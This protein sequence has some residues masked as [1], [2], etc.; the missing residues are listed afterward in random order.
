MLP[1]GVRIDDLAHDQR[2]AL[3]VAFYDVQERSREILRGGTLS[4]G[5]LLELAIFQLNRSLNVFTIFDAVTRLEGDLTRNTQITAPTRY[6]RNEPLSGLWHAHFFDARFLVKNLENENSK[7]RVRELMRPYIGRFVGE[8]AG[9]IAH[10]MTVGAFERRA[11]RGAL[12]GECI[13]FDA[14]PER[15]YYLTVRRHRE[16]DQAVAARIAEYRAADRERLRLG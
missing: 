15:N 5:F 7:K 9:Q 6:E 4:I 16:V 14:L 13:V 2:A 3:E 10:E 12:T 8:V 1:A 11:S